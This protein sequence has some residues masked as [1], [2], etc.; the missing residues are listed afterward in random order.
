MQEQEK[1]L[2][3]LC[4]S[5]QLD[6]FTVLYEKYVKKIYDF[7]YY[8]TNHQANAE[9]LTST[10]FLKALRGIKK[11]DV[12]QGYFSAWL[13]KIAKNAVADYYRWRHET[14]SL[15]EV[16][17]LRGDEDI[18]ASVER[19]D[20]LEQIKK[21]INNLDP[22]QKEI[23]VLRVWQELSY[24]EIS[25][26]TGKSVDNCKVIFSRSLKLLNNMVITILLTILY[27]Y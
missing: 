20:K 17:D 4:Q 25:E 18:Q 12:E 16:W 11:F 21:A 7:I 24:Q 22:Q 5:G 27:F 19:L 15:E 23:I 8:K 13:Y 6:N 9:D 1:Q 26:I 10:V 3:L 14:S 2:I